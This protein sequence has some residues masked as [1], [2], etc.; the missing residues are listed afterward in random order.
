M[1]LTFCSE[2]DN[3]SDAVNLFL[4]LNDWL[5]MVPRREVCKHDWLLNFSE[6]IFTACDLQC[7]DRSLSTPFFKNTSKGT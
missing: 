2:G 6:G 3:I 7:S 4:N 5:K 1:L